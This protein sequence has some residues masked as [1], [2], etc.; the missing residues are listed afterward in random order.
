MDIIDCQQCERL[1]NFL[2]SVKSKHPDY[3]ARPVAAFGDVTA[4]L[5]IVGL[6]PGMHGANRTGRPFTGD[7]AGVL[8]YKTLHQFGFATSPESVSAVDDLQLIGCRI[9]NAVKCL[10]PENKPI[11][12]EIKQCNRYLSTELRQFTK[13]GGTAVL[14]LGTVAHR[15][16]LMGLQLKAKDYPFAHGAVHSLIQGH[17]NGKGLRLYDSYHCSRYNTQTKRLTAEMFE[18]VFSRIAADF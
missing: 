7:Y 3:H 5:L 8:L 6:A 2:R 13:N 9:T 11:P 1:Y 14:A 16:V 18:H 4:K 12:E 17:Q 10:P 15:A